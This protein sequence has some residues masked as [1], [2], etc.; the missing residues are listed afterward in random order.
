MKEMI[1]IMNDKQQKNKQKD[2]S[3]GLNTNNDKIS[4]RDLLVWRKKLDDLKAK[5][6][7]KNQHLDGI[8]DKLNEINTC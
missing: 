3:E 8:K 7:T 4:E 1:K 6:M 2:E 5:T